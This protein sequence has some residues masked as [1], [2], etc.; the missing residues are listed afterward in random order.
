MSVY[1]SKS[2]DWF[3]VLEDMVCPSPAGLPPPRIRVSWRVVCEVLQVRLLG[4]A[5]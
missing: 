4:H 1:E 5:M 3:H 2:V